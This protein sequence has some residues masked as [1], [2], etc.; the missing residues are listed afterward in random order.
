MHLS[1]LRGSA[2]PGSHSSG[3]FW[4]CSAAASQDR[5]D[6]LALKEDLA[7]QISEA[8][9]R[10]EW[11]PG[12]RHGPM[13]SQPRALLQSAARSSRNRRRIVGIRSARHATSSRGAHA[14][15]AMGRRG[16]R[17]AFGAQL[18]SGWRRA[19]AGL[20]R[21]HHFAAWVAQL[22]AHF[23]LT[24]RRRSHRRP[25]RLRGTAT[26]PRWGCSWRRPRCTRP[27]AH[28]TRANRRRRLQDFS[29]LGP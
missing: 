15:A 25:P 8:I 19:G 5:E 4:L 28:S 14:S 22:V 29:V 17:A 16:G 3:L 27:V 2:G 11:C 20:R 6:M 13:C 10:P 18:G 21:G 9:S 12:R 1:S 23:A 26:P 7:G 24:A